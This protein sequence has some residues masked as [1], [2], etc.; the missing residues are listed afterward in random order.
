MT[1]RELWA[2]FAWTFLMVTGVITGSRAFFVFAAIEGLY[3]LTLTLLSRA[4]ARRG[5]CPNCVK[6]TRSR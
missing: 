3:G 2:L 4:H 1:R 6:E 5:G